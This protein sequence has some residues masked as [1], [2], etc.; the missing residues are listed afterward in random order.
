MPAG[1]TPLTVEY[2]INLLAPAV[3]ERFRAT[4]TVVRSGRTLSVVDTEVVAESG[5]ELRPVARML[6]TLMCLEGTS[7]AP[8][9][10]S[11]TRQ[12]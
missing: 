5:S 12:A 7:D 3:G 2:K 11:G 8:E 10:P 6:A 4:G 1:S 9:T